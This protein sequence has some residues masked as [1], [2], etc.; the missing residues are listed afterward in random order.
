MGTSK[1]DYVRLLIQK[2]NELLEQQDYKNT[3][4]FWLIERNHGHSGWV[5]QIDDIY[6]NPKNKRERT[7]AEELSYIILRTAIGLIETTN[8]TGNTSEFMDV[9]SIGFCLRLLK[10]KAPPAL[11]RKT[12]YLISQCRKLGAPDRAGLI[13]SVEDL[14]PDENGAILSVEEIIDKYEKE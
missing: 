14:L 6:R 9:E 3:Y 8:P 13:V 7:F 1:Y 4:L 12:R 2:A 5:D 11:V 10:D